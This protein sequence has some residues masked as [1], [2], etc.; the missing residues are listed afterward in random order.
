M[1]HKKSARLRR[2]RK[3]RT[4]IKELRAQRLCI[5]RSPRHIYAQ[6]IDDVNGQV[7][8]SA[9]TVEAKMRASV[10][11]GGNIA[12]ATGVGKLIAENA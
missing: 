11:N 12:A 5:F 6:V 3:A 8:A 9:S 2:A 10:K 7:V 4:K 1:K